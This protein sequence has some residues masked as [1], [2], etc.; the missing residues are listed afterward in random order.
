MNL[1]G[2]IDKLDYL[3]D[4]GI[5]AIWLTPTLENDMYMSYHGYASTDLYKI[6]ER[7]GSNELYKELVNKA[8]EKGIKV[9][10]DHV[11]NHIGINHPWVS[12]LPFESWINGTVEHH[13]NA[14]HNKTS[15]VDIYSNDS[16]RELNSEGWF[17]DYMIDLNQRNEFVAN[18]LIQNTIWWIEYSGIDGIRED[19]YR[20]PTKYLCQTGQK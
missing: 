8:H 14:N 19:T 2:V 18:Y 1:Q 10:Y 6:D 13:E 15:I 3:S 5:T 4:L 16:A 7:F 12:N 11:S 9:I 17:T 20:T